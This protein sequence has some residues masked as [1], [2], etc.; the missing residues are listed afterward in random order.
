VTERSPN[1]RHDLVE[2]FSFEGPAVHCVVCGI[3]IDPSSIPAACSRCRSRAARLGVSIDG[4]PM[5]EEQAWE[6]EVAVH[7]WERSHP[8]RQPVP[9]S[10]PARV[11]GEVEA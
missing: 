7:E 2:S 6:A 9:Q 1:P 11:V 10:G 5:T 4:E 3:R 8:Q